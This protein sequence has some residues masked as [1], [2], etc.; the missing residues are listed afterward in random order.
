MQMDEK[1]RSLLLLLLVVTVVAPA[2][3]GGGG[4]QADLKCHQQGECW[5]GFASGYGYQPSYNHCLE[6]C[7]SGGDF[8]CMW[9]NYYGESRNDSGTQEQNCHL[10]IVCPTVRSVEG[11]V[12]GQK[13]CQLGKKSIDGRECIFFLTFLQ[14]LISEPE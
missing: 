6:F 7:R 12:Y 5:G 14:S 13:E 11:C 8:D 9:F 10:Y 4:G 2:V 1:K 3:L